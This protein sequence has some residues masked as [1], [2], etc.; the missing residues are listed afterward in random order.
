MPQIADSGLQS[1]LSDPQSGV[2]GSKLT[3]GL[4]NFSGGIAKAGTETQNTRIRNPIGYMTRFAEPVTPAKQP[5]S[6][7]K[8]GWQDRLLLHRKRICSEVSIVFHTIS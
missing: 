5:V 7:S 6:P 4:L 2:Y 8:K 3:L 1:P